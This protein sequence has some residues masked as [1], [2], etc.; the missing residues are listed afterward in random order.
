MIVWGNV[1]DSKRSSF[2][3]EAIVPQWV[4]WLDEEQD[5]KYSTQR[6]HSLSPKLPVTLIL[7]RKTMRAPWRGPRTPVELPGS[8]ISHKPLINNDPQKK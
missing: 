5:D 3:Q 2:D 6:E 4:F 8:L 1:H 7:Q